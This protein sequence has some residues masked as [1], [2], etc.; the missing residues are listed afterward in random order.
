MQ[1]GGCC[2]ADVQR[3][4]QVRAQVEEDLLGGQRT[5][6]VLVHLCRCSHCVQV[7]EDLHQRT[8]VCA[9][10]KERCEVISDDYFVSSVYSFLTLILVICSLIN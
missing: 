6:Q 3:C 8:V 7:K 9:V 4:P 1:V 10:F 5:V 2:C